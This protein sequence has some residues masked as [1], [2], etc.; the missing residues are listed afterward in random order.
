MPGVRIRLTLEIGKSLGERK[1]GAGFSGKKN[2]FNEQRE[3]NCYTRPGKPFQ[4][5]TSG[6]NFNERQK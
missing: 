5:K 1:E 4:R 2:N 6:N 3:N